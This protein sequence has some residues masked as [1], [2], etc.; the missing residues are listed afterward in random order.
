MPPRR[1]SNGR[2]NLNGMFFNLTAP[3]GGQPGTQVYVRYSGAIYN[4]WDYDPAS[5][6]YLRF[7]DTADAQ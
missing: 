1:A 6:K 4:R 7:S 5:G 2:Q 3:A